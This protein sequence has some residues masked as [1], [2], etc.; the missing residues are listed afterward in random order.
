MDNIIFKFQK[1]D[2]ATVVDFEKDFSGA[3]YAKCDGLLDK[4]KRKNIHIEKYAESDE[5]RVWHGVD[6]VREPTIITFTLYFIGDNRNEVYEAFYSYVSSGRI[7]YWD[8]KRLKKAYMVLVDAVN[9]SEDVYKGSTPYIAVDFKFQNLWGECKD[10]D[11]D[12]NIKQNIT[13][14]N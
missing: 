10:C 3:K 12:G 5:A 11:A 1:S 7:Y 8:T 6:V 13:H 14:E 4:G 2:S 9:P